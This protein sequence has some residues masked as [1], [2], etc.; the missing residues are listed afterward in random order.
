MNLFEPYNF[1]GLRLQN[2]IVMAPMTRS[3]AIGNV[4]NDLMAQYYGQRSSA[5]LI[6]TEGTAP[7]PNGLG[8][9]RIPGAF[10]EA[11]VAGWKKVTAAAHKGGA[12]I[13]LQLMHT[14]RVT[15]PANL[16]PGAEVVAPSALA[17][18]GQMWTDQAGMQDFPVP[19]ALVTSEIPAVIAEFTHAA[20]N[21]VRAG[22]DGIELHGANGYL[23]EQF[24]NP[25]TNQRTD[26]YGGS[27]ENR[28][29]FALEVAAAVAEAIG[30]GKSAIRLS[31]FN[32][33]NGMPEY[34][35][36]PEQYERLAKE[37]GKLELA[38][39]HLVNYTRIGETLNRAMK[40]A[41]GGTV[42][43]NGGL[44]RQ[45]AEAALAAGLGD[46]AAFASRFLANPDLPLRF[47][48]ELPLNAPNP[49]TF[50]TPGEQ[51]YIDYPSAGVT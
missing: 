43:V 40:K 15:H 17:A 44:D 5:G 16:S 19:R 8:Y 23:I 36:T 42:I 34:A 2:R 37:L 3:R 29:R 45:K 47:K 7:S 14:G 28:N 21:A 11:Q 22:F 39:I 51:G 24:I 1:G 31:P 32:T 26:A 4:P 18:P 6:I 27:L 41:F 13:F 50:Y 25:G 9:A 49:D 20:E 46:L 35:E 48:K 33:F 30:A 12:K 38:Y 10:S